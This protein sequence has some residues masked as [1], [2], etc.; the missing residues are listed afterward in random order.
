[1]KRIAK[2]PFFSTLVVILTAVGCASPEPMVDFGQQHLEAHDYRKALISF[3]AAIAAEE[4]AASHAGRARAL[5]SLNQPDAAAS[6]YERAIELEPTQAEWH[7]GLAVVRIAQGKLSEAIASCDA[8][9]AL[10]KGMPRAYYNRAFAH[11]LQGEKEAAFK[12]YCWAID[13]NPKFAEAFNCRGILFAEQGATANAQQD[14]Q[15]A[16]GLAPH[17]ASA[18]GNLASVQYANGEAESAF[19]NLNTA[20]KVERDNPLYYKN[21]GMIYLDLGKHLLARK[22]FEQALA[23]APE[24]SQLRELHAQTQTHALAG[25]SR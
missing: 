21:R 4:T 23:L 22:D 25:M 5:A 2:T 15:A 3:D 10:D 24:D 13:A 19:M 20:I 9:I 17:L 6:A 14:F 16:I 12:N 1:M 7:L 8:A 11:Q 18:Y